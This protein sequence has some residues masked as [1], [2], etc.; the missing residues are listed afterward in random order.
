MVT[1]RDIAAVCDILETAFE[2]SE[3][4][5]QMVRTLR[6]LA[7]TSPNDVARAVSVVL[8]RQH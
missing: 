7:R 8:R 2:R 3:G 4:L 6:L 5:T 1:W